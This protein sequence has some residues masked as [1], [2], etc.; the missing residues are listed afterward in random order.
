MFFKSVKNVSLKL[1][2]MRQAQKPRNLLSLENCELIVNWAMRAFSVLFT[3]E[4]G[5]NHVDVSTVSKLE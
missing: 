5:S 4:L 3:V 2:T 1:L